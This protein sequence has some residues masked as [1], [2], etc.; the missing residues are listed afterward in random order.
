MAKSREVVSLPWLA[1]TREER[2]ARLRAFYEA[3]GDKRAAQVAGSKCD[4][5]LANLCGDCEPILAEL[6]GGTSV[7]E[8]AK[9]WGV[10]SMAIYG[11]LLAY[12]PEEF[13]AVSAN[14]ALGRKVECEERLEA[15]SDNVS[16][17]KWR[18]LLQSTEWELERVA[19]KVFGVKQPGEGLQITV[20][21]DRSCGGVVDVSGGGVSQ[22]LTISGAEA[23]V[24]AQ[25]G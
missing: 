23:S 22:R 15:A 10:T 25:A 18:A 11:H 19:P 16:V 3:R 5:V 12:A 6:Y 8:L 14:R 7:A 13:R 1:G 21:L 9:R 17:S 24:G 4:D 2:K 20:N